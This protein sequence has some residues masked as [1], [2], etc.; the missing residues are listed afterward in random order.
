MSL[1]LYLGAHWTLINATQVTNIFEKNIPFPLQREE[2][3]A[4]EKEMEKQHNWMDIV[5]M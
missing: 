4:I 1:Y 3:K 5:R 2:R